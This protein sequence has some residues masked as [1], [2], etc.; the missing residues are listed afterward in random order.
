MCLLTPDM[1]NYSSLCTINLHRHIDIINTKTAF[2][3]ELDASICHPS[4]IKMDSFDS[5]FLRSQIESS[6]MRDFDAEH[7]SMLSELSFSWQITCDILCN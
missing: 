7:T 5:I 2:L 3:R 6:E 1:A 4:A